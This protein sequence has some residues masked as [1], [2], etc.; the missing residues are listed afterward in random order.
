MPLSAKDIKGK[1]SSEDGP[2]KNVV[3]SDGKNFAI[4]DEKGEYVLKADDGAQ[5][6]YVVTPSGYIAP[7]SQGTPQFYKPLTASSFDFNLVG[8]GVPG[9]RYRLIALADPQPLGEMAYRR[10]E[11]EGFAALKEERLRADAENIPVI[12]VI[13]GDIVWDN[14]QTYPRMKQLLD[15][16]GLPVYTV[17]GNHDHDLQLA[18]D[19]QAA[20]VYRYF[21]GP[22]Y[23]AFNAGNDYFIVL[24]DL[25]YAGNKKYQEGMD[26]RQLDWVKAYLQY[27]PKGSHLFVCIHA[28]AYFY[29]PAYRMLRADELMALFE[30]YEVTV[31]SGHTHVNYNHSITPHIR[32]YNMAALGS[33]WWKEDS[34]LN[35]DGT[36]FGYH[37]FDFDGRRLTNYWKSLYHDKEYQLKA[38]LPGTVE[39]H[40]SELV[41]KVWNWDERWTVEWMEDGKSKGTMKRFGGTDPDYAAYVDKQRMKGDKK[42]SVGRL[43]MKEVPFFFSARPSSKARVVVIKATD[44]YGN[45]YTES[46]SLGGMSK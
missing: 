5:F 37:V 7:L 3:V 1:V 42:I 35:H 33:L 22:E 12:S 2:L 32:E 40:D 23:Y 13:M 17:I 36:P 45:T 9:G 21:F 19:V 20:H 28:P 31:L 6:V 27:V 44:P 8:F 15:D 29:K 10:L 30:G 24:D 34:K 26:Q 4:T 16:T 11:Q 18:D 43:P 38:Y 14:L 41:V 39:G 46:V 25:L